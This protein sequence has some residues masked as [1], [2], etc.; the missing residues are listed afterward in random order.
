MSNKTKVVIITR[1]SE[2]LE[3]NKESISGRDFFGN[4]IKEQIFDKKEISEPPID[5]SGS[6]VKK[7]LAVMD[8]ANKKYEEYNPNN[9]E[10]WVWFFHETFDID[11]D[12]K[13]D[14][15]QTMLDNP[16]EKV[17]A[18]VKETEE[19][20]SHQAIKDN[21][22]YAVFPYKEPGKE[23]GEEKEYDIYLL[24]WDQLGRDSSEKVIPFGS[25]I[26]QVCK[27]C[28][29]TNT[30]DDGKTNNLLY[31]HD[32]QLIGIQCDDTVWN[33]FDKNFVSPYENEPYF[34]VLKQYFDYVAIFGH[35][36]TDGI[37]QDYILECKFGQTDADKIA[38]EEANAKN[39]Q[40]LRNKSVNI[41][42]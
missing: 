34:E 23:P 32:C 17:T 19:N 16:N 20:K 37:F 12:K 7:F 25:F 33:K 35:K 41:I 1:T 8:T 9:E 27:D 24:L 29:I 6:S 5:S 4:P 30:K 38:L 42:E 2:F 36:S 28:N 21:K 22:C 10:Q 31:I 15:I 26:K 3:P 39:F 40:D 11:V 13:E 14:G 18:A